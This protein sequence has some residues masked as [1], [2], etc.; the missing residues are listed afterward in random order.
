M[1]EPRY[2]M[3]PLGQ[4][5]DPVT[6]PRQ[7]SSVFRATWDD[8]L[9][10]LRDEAEHLDVTYPIVIQVD[11][12]EL[13]LRQDGMLR[14][15]ARVG[16]CPGVIVSFTSKH[17][18]LRY[19]SDAY[20][21]RW[22]GSPP[23]WQANVRAIALALTALRAVDRY[24]VSKTGQQYTGWR[25]IEAGNGTAFPSADAALAWMQEMAGPNVAG[26]LTPGAVW[27]RL[28]RRMH[29]DVPGSD[30]ADWDR[31]QGARQLLAAAGML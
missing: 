20:D 16:D 6:T 2:Q 15:K 24:G 31:L 11:V 13:D 7:S 27:N 9:V 22:Q 12:T 18:P 21:Q 5:T 28:A 8:T 30:P 19:A 1:A 10:L 29:P 26:A 14:S 23:G 17:G 4:W 25:A 3:R